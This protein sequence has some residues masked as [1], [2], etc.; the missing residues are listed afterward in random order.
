MPRKAADP[1][2]VLLFVAVWFNL[3]GNLFCLALCYFV[4]GFVSPFSS[5]ITSLGKERADLSI[6]R[7]F[8]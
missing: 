3:R 5:A 6:F 8:V 7:T 4:L 1:V 2:F